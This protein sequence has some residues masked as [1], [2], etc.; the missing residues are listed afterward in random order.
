[1]LELMDSVFRRLCHLEKF[2]R[3]FVVGMTVDRSDGKRFFDT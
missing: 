3:R 1:M 2:F